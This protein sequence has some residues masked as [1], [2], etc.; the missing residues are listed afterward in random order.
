MPYALGMSQSKSRGERCY[1]L[2]AECT[3]WQEVAKRAGVSTVALTKA[4][5]RAADYAK[6]WAD[7]H[8]KPW[9]HPQSQIRPRGRPRTGDAT[10][11]TGTV[12]SDSGDGVSQDEASTTRNTV[13]VSPFDVG[14]VVQLRSG[15]VAMTVTRIGSA[16][17]TVTCTWSDEAGSVLTREF[18]DAGR[19][20]RLVEHDDAVAG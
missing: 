15:G 8:D 10:P 11:A 13:F 9:P 14:D 1:D 6:R 3:S 2:A 12:R 18:E 5:S 17:G 16:R 7:R 4:G 20:L 19:I